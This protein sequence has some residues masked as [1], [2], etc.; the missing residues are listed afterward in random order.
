MKSKLK[1]Y[2]VKKLSIRQ[3]S[4]GGRNRLGVITVNHRAAAR[5]NGS[6]IK[7]QR[8]LNVDFQY[9]F[10]NIKYVL[11]NIRTCPKRNA[12]IGTILLKNGLFAYILVSKNMIVGDVWSFDYFRNLKLG[13]YLKVSLIPEG[14]SIFNVELMLGSGGQVARSAGTSVKI[15]NRYPNIYNKILV[16]FR[17]GE[18]YF[19]NGNCGA[20]IGV[21]SNPDYWL[22]ELKTAGARRRKGRRSV[23]RGVAMNPIDHPHGGNT[24]G[25]IPV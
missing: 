11:L 7:Q 20:T 3:T 2:I 18:E 5:S 10:T 1:N 4:K 23:V 24:N 14:F 25:V 12:Y 6:A 17:S 16:R 13:D 8:Y 15:I 9:S 21:C 19:I 22:M